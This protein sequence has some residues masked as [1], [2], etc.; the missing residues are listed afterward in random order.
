MIAQANVSLH[1]NGEFVDERVSVRWH[2]DFLIEPTERIDL[3]GC[4]ARD[5]SFRWPLP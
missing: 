5:S 1:E 4:I 3:H 2:D